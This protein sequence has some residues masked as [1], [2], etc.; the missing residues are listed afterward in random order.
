VEQRKTG[1]KQEFNAW[2]EKTKQEMAEKMKEE[3]KKKAND[4]IDNQF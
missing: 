1:A 4:R 2:L 3:A